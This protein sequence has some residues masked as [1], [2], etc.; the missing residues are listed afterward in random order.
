MERFLSIDLQYHL[1]ILRAAGNRRIVK[2]VRDARLLIRILAMPLET[3]DVDQLR[4]ISDDHRRILDA[5]LAGD[6]PLSIHLCETHIRTSRQERLDDYDRWERMAQ[7]RLED[8]L[9]D[10]FLEIDSEP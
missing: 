6:A 1:L 8:A 4:H 10:S 2:L 7:M 5:I 9:L 3:H